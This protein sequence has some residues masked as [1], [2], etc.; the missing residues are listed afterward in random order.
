M[1]T[2]TLHHALRPRHRAVHQVREWISKGR[3]TDG[4]VLPSERE[5]AQRL[6]LARG[7]VRAALSEL[8]NDG[9]I[10]LADG[11][12]RRVQ[13]SGRHGL[14]ASTI[15]LL[16]DSPVLSAPEHVPLGQD[17]FIQLAV[18]QALTGIGR[19]VLNL[20]P[21]M[22]GD[23]GLKQL[24]AGRPRGAIAM[25]AVAA[26]PHGQRVIAALKAAGIATTTHSDAHALRPYDHVTSDQ[27]R[28]GY[29]VTRWLLAH[30]RRRIRCFWRFPAQRDWADDR[31]AGYAQA[32]REAG[33]SPLPALR[34]P[35]LDIPSNTAEGF[36]ALASA[37]SGFLHQPATLDA[38]RKPGFDALITATDGHAYQSAAA[39]RRLGLLPGREVLVTGY[40]HLFPV[41]PERAFEPNGLAA[42]VDKDNPAMARELVRLLDARLAGQ[43]PAAAQRLVVPHRLIPLT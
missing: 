27:H 7:T 20:S 19:H 1:P 41:C 9:V 40:D 24:I 15:A 32:M 34:T 39:C 14:M 11:G 31:Y 10:S 18:T 36:T 43:L 6:G 29:D 26:S 5:L 42:T 33:L 4:A 2:T 17:S 12:V 25:Y 35:E 22:L 28:G 16:T 21:T 13:G 3:L 23:D 38:K 30:G 37:L 8:T